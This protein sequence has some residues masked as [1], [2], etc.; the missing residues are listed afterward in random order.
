MKSVRIMLMVLV[1]LCVSFSLTAQGQKDQMVGPQKWLFALE[2]IEGSVQDIYAQKFKEV[3]E[4]KTN[5]EVEVVIYAYGELGT[6][7]DIAEQLQGNAINFAFQS[8]GALGSYVPEVQIFSLHYL[9]PAD[10]DLASDIMANSPAI[11]EILGE[12]YLAKNLQLLDII[13]EGWQ[14]WSS[15]KPLR[16][17]EDFRGVKF[18]VM[19]SPML[20]EAYNA[21][22]ANTVS[23]DYAEIYSGLQLKQI[24][25]QV[26]PYFAQQEMKF[27]EVQNYLTKADQLQFVATVATNPT[28]YNKLNEV[29]K[30]AVQEAVSIAHDYTIEAQKILNEERKAMMAKAKPSLQFIQLTEEEKSRF[31]ALAQTTYEKYLNIGGPRAKELLDALILEIERQTEN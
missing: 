17:P 9:L 25:A 23:L 13:T 15:N 4:E 7:G 27:Y 26:Q 2:E 22:G 19:S 24:D 21:Y 31:K 30:Q 16:T 12:Q 10:E 14:I 29:H 3:V 1:L 11:Y 18:R 20:I 6:S 28:F 5:G 8:P